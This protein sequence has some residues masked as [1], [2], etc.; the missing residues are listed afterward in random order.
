MVCA[1]SP[2][3][4]MIPGIFVA[5]ELLRNFILI[6]DE[7]CATWSQGRAYSCQQ[8]M[9]AAG[10][11]IHHVLDGFLNNIQNAALPAGMDI[12]DDLSNR[13][14]QEYGLAIRCLNQQELSGYIGDHGIPLK[15]ISGIAHR[16]RMNAENMSA[17]DLMDFNQLPTPQT[18]NNGSSIAPD[19]F[20]CIAHMHAHVKTIIGR[21][22]VAVVASED[23]MD[24]PGMFSQVGKFKPVETVFCL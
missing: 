4:E 21:V 1:E 20:G 3:V 10:K 14:I 9:G 11:I 17:V 23:S 15:Q 13:I 7:L 24:E 2:K 12:G 22:A 6:M 18:I 5:P 16:P 8:M 19:G